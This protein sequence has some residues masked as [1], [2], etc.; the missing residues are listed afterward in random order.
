[1]QAACGGKPAWAPV[2]ALSPGA[3]LHATCMLCKD[4]QLLHKG[5]GYTTNLPPKGPQG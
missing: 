2:P 3:Q 5:A 4:E 1:M